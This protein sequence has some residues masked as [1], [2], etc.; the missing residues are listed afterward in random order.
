MGFLYL[1]SVFFIFYSLHPFP[2]IFALH[3][4]I[5]PFLSF[6]KPIWILVGTIP[7]K[8]FL[9]WFKPLRRKGQPTPLFLPGKFHGQRS[10]A[11]FSP[12]GRK[13]SAMT[14]WL[15]TLILKIQIS[16]LSVPET[17]LCIS[18]IIFIPHKTFTIFFLFFFKW[19]FYMS[20]SSYLGH[21]P[22]NNLGS[23]F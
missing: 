12:W 5:V 6:R 15:S 11:G 1:S 9:Y 20:E 7:F 22:L 8:I 16:Y 14:E 21:S 13:E 4:G 18:W 23:H 10:L 3:D 19:I 17:F 2:C